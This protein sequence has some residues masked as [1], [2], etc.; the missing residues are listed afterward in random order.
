[1]DE[2][3]G[4]DALPA[5]P[6]A[7]AALSILPAGPQPAATAHRR[8]PRERRRPSA[9]RLAVAGGLAVLVAAVAV[10]AGTRSG[11]PAGPQAGLSPAAFVM[12]ATTSTLAQRTA[13]VSISGSVT[14]RGLTIPVTGTGLTDFRAQSFESAL[15]FSASGVR[16]QEHELI[17]AQRFYLGMVVNGTD[18]MAALTGKQW[19]LSPFSVAT[20]PG[21]SL[22]SGDPVSQLRLLAAHGN[23]VTPLGTTTVEGR[24]LSGYR[25]VISRQAVTA[26]MQRELAAPGL[27]AAERR[28]LRQAEAMLKPP[29]I[30]AW[31]DSAG[32][33]RQMSMQ[34]EFSI[35]SVSGGGTVTMTF[36]HYGVPVHIAALPASD[37][38][39]YSAFLKAAAAAP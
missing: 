25:V 36:D 1:M 34:M 22:G 32:L 38:G 3:S 27:T 26:S 9:R 5:P 4:N 20:Q 19:V 18:V 12:S 6:A 28:L 2:I 23:T 24:R 31:F 30:E 29:T 8:L 21:T 37:V 17:V 11:S 14:V 35:S 7:P 39:S 15:S 13:D 16:V 33:L 10:F